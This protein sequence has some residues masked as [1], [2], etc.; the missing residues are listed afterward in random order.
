MPISNRAK[1]KQDLKSIYWRSKT[2][3]SCWQ[4]CGKF[5]RELVQYFIDQNAI[6]VEEKEVSRTA[7]Y[8]ERERKDQELEL[9][10]EQEHAVVSDNREDWPRCE[11]DLARRN[12]RKWQD[13][14]LSSSNWTSLLQKENCYHAGSWISDLQM[15]DRFV[16]ALANRWQSF[17]LVCLMVK[18]MTNGVGRKRKPRS[19]LA[20]SA[21]FALSKIL[22]IIIDES[23]SLHTSRILIR[24]PCSRSCYSPSSV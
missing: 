14:S 21:V 19:L 11:S 16:P 2:K 9:N 6:V 10:S 3:Y 24:V 17:I 18:N 13:R 20:R 12:Y 23:T 1:R 7:S 5:S 22:V 4:I 15:T 8:F